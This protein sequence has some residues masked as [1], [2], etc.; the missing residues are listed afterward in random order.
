MEIDEFH[1]AK[2]KPG[3]QVSLGAV[4]GRFRRGLAVAP[5]A[6]LACRR[7]I[8]RHWPMLAPDMRRLALSIRLRP[9]AEALDPP[10]AIG[11]TGLAAFITDAPWPIFAPAAV[12]LLNHQTDAAAARAGERALIRMASALAPGGD[13][14]LFQPLYTPRDAPGLDG[15]TEPTINRADAERFA[16]A[17]ADAAWA[18]EA[19]ERSG[20]IVAA[21]LLLDEHLENPRLG[22]GVERLRAL[23]EPQPHPAHAAAMRAIR[24]NRSPAMRRRAWVWSASNALSRSALDRIAEAHGLSDHEALLT[25]AHLALR[26]VRAAAAGLIDAGLTA[27]DGQISIAP[28]A[29]L[30]A[31]LQAA[32]LSTEARR[33]LVR[34]A[35]LMRMPQPARSAL[36]GANLADKDPA[37]RLLT[38][39]SQG[40]AVHPDF[41]LDPDHRVARAAILRWSRADASA[42]I[43]A[44]LDAPARERLRLAS[45]LARSPHADVRRLAA[46]ESAVHD[47]FNPDRPAS[48]LLAR[49]WLA[50]RP[51][52]FLS[53]LRARLDSAAPAV[54][55]PALRLA[56][57]LGLTAQLAP[58]LRDLA[59]LHAGSFAGAE[60]VAASAVIA[61]G[62]L[63][64]AAS[65][66][67]LDIALHHDDP[68]VRANAV[69]AVA[70]SQAGTEPGRARLLEAKQDPHHRVRANALRGLLALAQ[71]PIARYQ[72]SLLEDLDA[73]LANASAR[74]R[75]AGAWCAERVA[76]RIVERVAQRIAEPHAPADALARRVLGLAEA[77]ND[78]RVRARAAR[79]AMRLAAAGPDHQAHP[80]HANPDHPDHPAPLDPTAQAPGPTDGPPR[81][82]LVGA[83]A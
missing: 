32:S 66:P 35:P 4:I 75:L 46:D 83:V 14:A 65:A 31:P 48:R 58:H 30:P 64:P 69:E 22:R 28:R 41:I 40:P 26:P 43:K 27:A 29:A 78:Q 74:H 68:R 6:D 21:L 42:S 49:R 37:V 47:P 67:A 1:A 52:D 72:A 80:P 11:P 9:W 8:A 45:L 38:V 60:R 36:A 2:P 34:L 44:P 79:V 77:D 62:D 71:E 10:Q 54:V 16:E 25:S 53:A 82:R 39:A 15:V 81:L 76:E 59:A 3:A 5:Q 19:H 56:R 61:M 33:G 57:L 50:R 18:F 7:V 73:M 51:D 20:P 55:L 17:L 12:W 13:W 23:L 24:R 70:A 63:A